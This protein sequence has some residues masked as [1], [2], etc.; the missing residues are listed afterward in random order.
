MIKWFK[1]LRN[2][3][4]NYDKDMLDLKRIANNAVIRAEQAEKVIRDRTDIHTDIHYRAESYVI[5]V[6]RYGKRDYIQ[7]FNLRNEDFASLIPR[8]KEMERYGHIKKVDAHPNFKAVFDY[9]FHR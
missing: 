9:E 8:L 3:V 1:Q 4:A 7:G 2:I 6:G 5:V